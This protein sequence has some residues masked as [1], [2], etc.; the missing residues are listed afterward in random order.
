MSA[1]RIGIALRGKRNGNG[2]L[3]SCPCPNHG[4][5]RGDRN[6]SLSIT[7]GDDG[8]LLIRCFAGCAYED[9]ME[10]FRYR[11]LAPAANDAFTK[12]KANRFYRHKAANPAPIKPDPEALRIWNE[13]K[14]PQGTVVEQY[15][16]RRGIPLL[17]PRVR[18]GP[19][20]KM[21]VGVE[22]PRSGVVAIQTTPVDADGNRTGNRWTKGELGTGAVRLGAAQEIMGVA[23]GTETALSAMTLTGMSVWH[24]WEL[25]GCTRSNC[26]HSFAAYTFSLTLTSLVASL[27]RRP[28]RF[29]KRLGA[30]CGFNFR[31]MAS[32]ISMI[33]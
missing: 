4:N 2:W 14:H 29:T 5:G 30:K 3:I 24:R 9:V 26:L 33:F 15:L 27:R 21:V 13:T 8:K 10:Q 31:P 1:A 17:P 12:K 16:Q 32:K 22:A 6:P 25:V 28:P 11:G 19:D 20:G 23:E 18:I 7:D